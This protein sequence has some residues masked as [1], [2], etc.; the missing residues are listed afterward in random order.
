MTEGIAL[1]CGTAASI[2][3]LHTLLGPDHY[4]P[5]V[6]MSRVGGWPLGK[7]VVITLLCGIAHVMS[8]M[9]LGTVGIAFGVAVLKLE[10]I[11]ASRGD[12][13][14]WL[15]LAFGL[16][17]FIW[18]LRRAI[19]HKPHAH[20][21]GHADGT[22]HRHDHVHTNKH[23]HVH[24]GS[25]AAANGSIEG[26]GKRG[27]LTPWVLFTIFLFGPCE[28]LI[29]V[30]MYPAAKGNMWDVAIVTAVFGLT[31][32][33]TMTTAVIMGCLAVQSAGLVRLERYSDA[34]A[35]LAVLV[36]G[37]AIKAGL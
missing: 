12:L 32:L 4:I 6:A 29:P 5:F 11:E 7:T 10:N 37:A 14:G 35:G 23:V 24:D 27:S 30:L 36:C 19:R 26:K 18:G 20:V 8:S 17:Y 9:I 2:G 33:A 1:V 22:V 3:F 21:H 15:L 25:H 13:A 28:P 34:L 16:V 31:T